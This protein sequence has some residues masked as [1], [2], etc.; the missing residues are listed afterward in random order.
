[1][2]RSNSFITFPAHAE[3][4]SRYRPLRWNDAPLGQYAPRIEQL[5]RIHGLENDMIRCDLFRNLLQ[6]KGADSMA[7]H[8]VISFLAHEKPE[9]WTNVGFVEAKPPYLLTYLGIANVLQLRPPLLSQRYERGLARSEDRKP[10]F[11][12]DHLLHGIAV[13][14]EQG[15]AR[16]IILREVVFH[17]G[18]AVG[19]GGGGR[20]DGD[21]TGGNWA[22]RECRRRGGDGE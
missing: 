18:R 22:G 1:M 15:R 3:E 11:G 7:H 19:Y 16:R 2:R 10:L 12:L 6:R 20:A 21:A 13:P 17:I 4:S 8:V 14:G 9:R 5:V